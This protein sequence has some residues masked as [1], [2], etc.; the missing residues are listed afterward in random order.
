MSVIGTL[1]PAQDGGWTGAIQTLTINAKT[2]VVPNDNRDGE[3]S[4]A[5]NVLLGHRRIGEAW[6]AHSAGDSPKNYLRVRFDDPSL[7][8]PLNAALFPSEDGASAQLVW[9]RRRV[10]G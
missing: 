3:E 5:F 4:P 8:A 2:R 9:T 6:E 10:E 7:V 1:M